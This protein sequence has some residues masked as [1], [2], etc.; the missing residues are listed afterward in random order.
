MYHFIS[1]FQTEYKTN[2]KLDLEWPGEIHL[3]GNLNP[4]K[5][6][7]FI[8][9]DVLIREASKAGFQIIKANYIGRDLKENYFSKFGKNKENFSSLIAVKDIFKL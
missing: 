7:N 6:I 5:T 1:S 4:F 9:L 3:T 2:S 8:P